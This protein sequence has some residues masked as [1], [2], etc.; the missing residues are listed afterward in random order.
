VQVQSI[1]PSLPQLK[2]SPQTLTVAASSSAN[3]HLTWL[4]STD[5]T[6][7]TKVHTATLGVRSNDP[8]AP[9]QSVVVQLTVKG[10]K[11]Q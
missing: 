8:V 9:A 11:S 10:G 2:V 3:V 5:T 1:T 7:G 4:I 6:P